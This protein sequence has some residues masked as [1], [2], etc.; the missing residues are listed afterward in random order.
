[1]DRIT[2]HL[3]P[4]GA[5]MDQPLPKRRGKRFAL[6]GAGVVAALALGATLW[7]FVPSGLQVPLRDVRIASVEKGVFR[8]DIVVRATTE[9]LKSVILDSVESG[10]VEEVLATDGA[11]VKKGQLLFRLS[12]PQRN[13]ELLARQAEH[14]QQISNL[15]NLRVAQEA[16][17][18]EH[19]RRLSDLEFALSQGEKQHARNVKLAAQGFIS[20]VS[21]EESA[22]RVA[23]QRRAVQI[24]REATSTEVKVKQDALAQL[25]RATRE[26]R[27]GLD[28]V[29]AT[30]VA[31][32]VRAP[33]DGMLADFRLQVGQTVRPDQNLG[34]IDDPNRF[35]LTAQVDE[36][37]LNRVAV[38][39]QGTVK[40]ADQV[41]PVSVSTIYPQIKEGRFT[42]EMV[43]T[44]GQP[45]VM[46]PGQGMDAQ[47]T[48]GEPAPATLLPNG[49][50]VNDSGGAWV[51]VLAA[52]GQHVEKRT[53]RIGRRSNSQIEIL[54]GLAPGEQVIVS[55]Y[56]GFGKAERLQLIK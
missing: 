12:N 32:A 1:M 9:P 40:Q 28:L 14:A 15:S 34:R 16:N 20:S 19:R 45:P 42:V 51:F 50:F 37:Y 2:P 38:G 48:L 33:V 11:L 3:A 5:A 53:V 52:D 17:N 56:A 18:S 8:D 26:L 47:I 36:F 7:S 6:I 44:K 54:S 55:G 22:D 24:E 49:A 4:S 27:S 10:R 30:V 29:N 23:Q 43:F 39:R 25:D 21:L 46:S 41:Y 35:K 31:L 13:L